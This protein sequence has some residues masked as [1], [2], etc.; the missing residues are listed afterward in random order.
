MKKVFLLLLL[1]IGSG[2]TAAAQSKADAILGEWINEKKDA[3]FQIFK[4]GDKYFGKIIWGT[5][6]QTKDTKN[7][8]SKLRNRE[9]IGLTILKN[10]VFDGDDTWEDGTIYDPREGKT[11]SCKITQKETNK[12]N[13]RGF[14]GI[15]LFGRTEVWTKIK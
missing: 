13:V 6:D 2:S 3:K 8:D 12:I 7:P 10:F 9:L 15:S 4:Q 1:I 14:V 5:G 11:Y